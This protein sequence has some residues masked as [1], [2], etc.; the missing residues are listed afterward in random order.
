MRE[1]D[2]ATCSRLIREVMSKLLSYAGQAEEYVVKGVPVSI[3]AKVELEEMSSKLAQLG[4]F[5]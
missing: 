3:V 4:S 2:R 5:I 1:K